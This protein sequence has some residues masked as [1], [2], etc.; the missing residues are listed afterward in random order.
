MYGWWLLGLDMVEQ[1]ISQILGG[2]KLERKAIALM[3]QMHDKKKEGKTETDTDKTRL[4]K[5]NK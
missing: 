1:G 3:A 4:R 5:F 2:V